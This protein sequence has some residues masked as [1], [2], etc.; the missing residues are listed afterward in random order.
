M[1]TH[2]IPGEIHV[3]AEVR[4]RLDGQYR[5]RPRGPIEIK[6]KGMMKTFLLER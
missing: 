4:R 2:G 1:E 5:F 3:S 6:G